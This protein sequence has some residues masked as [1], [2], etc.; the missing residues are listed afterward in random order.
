M[1]AISTN[2]GGWCSSASGVACHFARARQ[3]ERKTRARESR[4]ADTAEAAHRAGRSRDR[5]H[6]RHHRQDRRRAELA[7][8]FHARSK[9]GRAARPGPRRCRKRAGARR[10]GMAGGQCA[11]RRSGGLAA[12]SIVMPRESGASGK[13]CSRL[14][15]ITCATEYRAPGQAGRRRHRLRRRRLLLRFRLGGLRL[16]RGFLATLDGRQSPGGEGIDAGARAMR[17][18]DDGD[19]VAARIIGQID[20]VRRADAAHHVAFGVAERDRST[21]FAAARRPRRRR[22]HWHQPGPPRAPCPDSPHRH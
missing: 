21:A 2:T 8:Y 3:G 13:R 15:Q 20:A 19:P 14:I 4:E 7:G 12:R 5:A 10:G 9:A 16:R 18:G 17:I 6:Q 11:V 1:T 22:A